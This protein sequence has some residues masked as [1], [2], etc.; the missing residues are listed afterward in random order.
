[1]INGHLCRCAV[2]LYPSAGGASLNARTQTS[3][4]QAVGVRDPKKGMKIKATA[5]TDGEHTV[6]EQ[7]KLAF[8]QA[9]PLA[10]PHRIVSSM[11]G[12]GESQIE[13]RKTQECEEIEDVH[14]REERE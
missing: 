4:A 2:R 7:T 1:V 11:R 8:R 13:K 5:L 3:T 12:L 9:P 6:I 10:T 14:H